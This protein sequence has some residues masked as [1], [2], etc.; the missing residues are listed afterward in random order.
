MK[1]G[2]GAKMSL[3]LNAPVKSFDGIVKEF[4]KYASDKIDEQSIEKKL[5]TDTIEITFLPIKQLHDLLRKEKIG[6]AKGESTRAIC[7]SVGDYNGRLIFSD[8]ILLIDFLSNDFFHERRH[9]KDFRQGRH[10]KN[11]FS[12]VENPHNLNNLVMEGLSTVDPI[13]AYKIFNNQF[14]RERENLSYFES[15]PCKSINFDNILA[16]M[17]IRYNYEGNEAFMD[18]FISRVKTD[19]IEAARYLKQI[20]ISVKGKDYVDTVIPKRDF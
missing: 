5:D 3:N 11:K 16:Y 10:S 20:E 12:K 13:T 1:F 19:V 8:D 2:N 6:L 15:Y 14:K 17:G 9:L 4:A 7:T 18:R